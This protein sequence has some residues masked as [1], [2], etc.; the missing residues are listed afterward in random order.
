L[1]FRN[2]RNERERERESESERQDNKKEVSDKNN[3]WS[4]I[5]LLIGS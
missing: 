1:N 3:L 5:G 2:K 4:L